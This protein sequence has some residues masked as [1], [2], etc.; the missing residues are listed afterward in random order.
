MKT[1]LLPYD[2]NLGDELPK[3]VK[4]QV[5]KRALEIIKKDKLVFGL[6]TSLFL[7]LLLPCILFDLTMYLQS[8]PN[9][10]VWVYYLTKKSFPEIN[11]KAIE[12]LKMSSA[13]KKR[14]I[15]ELENAIAKLQ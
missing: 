8:Q 12:K 15:L 10:K 3:E 1:T 5:Y 13:I 9:G 11:Y 7:C 14:R 6:E 4:L 2:C